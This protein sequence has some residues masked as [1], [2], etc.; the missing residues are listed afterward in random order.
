MKYKT[1]DII[2]TIHKYYAPGGIWM[3]YQYHPYNNFGDREPGYWCIPINSIAKQTFI[4]DKK[5]YSKNNLFILHITTLQ[6]KSHK[7]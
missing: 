3:I 7:I 6:E 1:G 5:F 2:K 4:T